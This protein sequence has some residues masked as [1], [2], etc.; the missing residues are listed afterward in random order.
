MVEDVSPGSQR[1]VVPTGAELENA[2][3]GV[4]MVDAEA[5]AALVRV[6]HHAPRTGPR[7]LLVLQPGVAQHVR[8]NRCAEQPARA[9]E[10]D[11]IFDLREVRR[12]RPQASLEDLEPAAEAERERQRGKRTGC[13]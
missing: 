1:G 4:G 3:R 5:G 8:G 10:R 9:G 2:E 11:D 7:G 6:L 12:G 13:A